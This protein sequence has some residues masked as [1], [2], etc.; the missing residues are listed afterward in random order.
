MVVKLS[1]HLTWKRLQLLMGD[2]TTLQ[3]INGWLTCL[4]LLSAQDKHL[5]LGV[6][7]N[8]ISL[9]TLHFHKGSRLPLGTQTFVGLK[10]PPSTAVVMR[11][12]GIQRG[13]GSPL[14]RRGYSCWAPEQ[15]WWGAGALPRGADQGARWLLPSEMWGP[16]E[17]SWGSRKWHCPSTG[18]YSKRLHYS[19][20]GKQVA[21]KPSVYWGF[22]FFFFFF[23]IFANDG[24]WGLE[25]NQP[26]WLDL[27]VTKSILKIHYSPWKFSS[28]RLPLF[29]YRRRG[30]V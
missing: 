22:A 26:Y 13:V 20:P 24:K 14:P 21:N 4:Y 8:T 6:L 27:E 7:T 11:H 2:L 15:G 30:R 19:C 17:A 16:Q 1:S 29:W 9:P 25:K 28:L 23:P 5:S 3:A 10:R 18:L 12:R